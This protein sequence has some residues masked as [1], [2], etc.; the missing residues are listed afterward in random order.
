MGFFLDELNLLEIL[1]S[2]RPCD[3]CLEVVKETGAGILATINH[4]IQV[5]GSGG[6]LHFQHFS[7]PASVPRGSKGFQGVCLASP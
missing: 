2:N 1:T 3:L 7:A 4:L 6:F 5:W